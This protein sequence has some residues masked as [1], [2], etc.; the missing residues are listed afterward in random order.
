VYCVDE[1]KPVVM[2]MSA[3]L[4]TNMP[5]IG[6]MIEALDKRGMRY[7]FHVM[8]GGAPFNQ[9]F[10]DAIGADTNGR[11]AARSSKMASDYVRVLAQRIAA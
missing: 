8:V 1:H 3:L 7:D 2:G 10:A 4:T 11:G 6:V 5:Y 9:E